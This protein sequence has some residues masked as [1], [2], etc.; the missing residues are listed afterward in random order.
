MAGSVAALLACA[1][2]GLCRTASAADEPAPAEKPSAGVVLRKYAAVRVFDIAPDWTLQHGTG[3]W[4][5][6]D[7]IGLRAVALII[8]GDSDGASA[9]AVKR[10]ND[11]IAPSLEGIRKQGVEP[12]LVVA[13]LKGGDSVTAGG[14]PLLIDTKKDLVS[15]FE[16]MPHTVNP[17]RVALVAI[18][19]AGFVRRIE[20]IKEDQPLGTLIEW[21]GDMTPVLEVGQPAPDFSMPDMH[22]QVRRLADLRGRK[23]LLL[24]FF[25]K[26]FTGGCANHLSSL[27]TENLAFL[28]AETEIWAVSVD[29]AEGEK[30]QIAFAAKL[31][32]D[33]P[34]LP[35]TGRNLC[36][37]YGATQ[38]REQKAR[39]MSVL[40]DKN[41]IVRF[42]DYN[43]NVRTHGPDVLAKM[44]ELDMIK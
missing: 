30:G 24:T 34:L 32:V 29:P 8:V 9:A 35:D 19:K 17:D 10:V 12:V 38:N 11:D 4:S 28:T 41:G 18:D 1:A 43:V 39:R 2:V 20:R 15:L 3:W 14:F 27:G 21:I 7:Q 36:I 37:L 25:P 22:G 16:A 23:N 40:I 6:H 13:G 33:F 31:D 44:R 26:C 5:L 42:V